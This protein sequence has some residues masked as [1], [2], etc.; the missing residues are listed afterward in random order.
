LVLE[1]GEIVEGRYRII[2]ELADGGM[3]TVFLAEH[4]LIKRKVALKV[5][6]ADLAQDATILRRF[7]NEALAAGTLGHPNIVESTDMG[8][9]KN[10]IPYIVFEYLEGT[11]LS[12][13]LVRVPVFPIA[14]ALRIAHQIAGAVHAAHAASI[15]HRD[16]KTDNIFLARRAGISDHVKVLD[17]GIS[18]FLAAS[19]RTHTGGGLLGP[20]EFM[21]P[22][23]LLTP[24]AIDHRVDIYALGV[25]LYEML[26]D[27]VPFAPERGGPLIS[28]EA[29]ERLFDRVINDKPPPIT[30]ADVPRELAELIE[31]RLLAKVPKWRPETMADVQRELEQIAER[32][33]EPLVAAAARTMVAIDELR[34]EVGF[35]G[36]RWTLSATDLVCE[37]ES[38]ELARFAPVVAAAAAF[39]DELERQPRIEIAQSRL[40]L[41]VPAPPAAVDVVFAARLE[42][43]LRNNGW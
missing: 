35:L 39:A 14:R 19:D 1:P 6:H 20:P 4:W 30:R 16:L 9:T 38:N 12:D 33:A 36:K 17:F 24:D 27:G 5:L 11:G 15:I 18:R 8:F 37:L 25:V 3:G 10:E 34:R 29:T 28:Y 7:M 43:W 26:T 42:A 40:R 41:A 22:E 21:A 13:E 2:R 31:A 32:H 23:Q